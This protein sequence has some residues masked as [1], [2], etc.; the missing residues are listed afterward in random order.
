MLV[1]SRVIEGLFYDTGAEIFL[2]NSNR[3]AGLHGSA[4]ED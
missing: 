3:S 4:F 2:R 1:S